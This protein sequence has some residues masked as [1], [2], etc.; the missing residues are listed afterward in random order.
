MGRYQD[1]KDDQ[2]WARCFS[3]EKQAWME[4]RRAMN[5]NNLSEWLRDA[6]NHY[7]EHCREQLEDHE[8]L[9]KEDDEGDLHARA[10]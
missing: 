4:M 7:Y 6:A 1:P 5:H 9:D 10:V 2:V 8:H 3:S